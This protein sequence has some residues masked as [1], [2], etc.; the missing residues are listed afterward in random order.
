M[1]PN[2]RKTIEEIF[3]K[4]K[5][6]LKYFDLSDVLLNR[7]T[8]EELE[9]LPNEIQEHIDTEK[10]H[11]RHRFNAA[12]CAAEIRDVVEKKIFKGLK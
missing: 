11:Q 5:L 7:L 2:T 10:E 9:N 8:N 6:P 1:T 12:A 3:E 4:N